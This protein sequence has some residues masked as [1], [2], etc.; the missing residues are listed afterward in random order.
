MC[1]CHTQFVPFFFG[2]LSFLVSKPTGLAPSLGLRGDFS[3]FCLFRGFLRIPFFLTLFA[4]SGGLAIFDSGSPLRGLSFP[5]PGFSIFSSFLSLLRLSSFGKDRNDTP[6][7]F[8][9]AG[10]SP[11]CPPMG[12][13]L[14]LLS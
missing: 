11:D 7:F 9:L 13:K 8:F 6:L 5:P 12:E 4:S 1:I 14:N 2:F 3:E 10:V